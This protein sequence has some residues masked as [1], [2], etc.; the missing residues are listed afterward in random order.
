[1]LWLSFP[2]DIQVYDPKHE[3]WEVVRHVILRDVFDMGGV[4][5][6]VAGYQNDGSFDVP[7]LHR[8]GDDGDD[9]MDVTHEMELEF[10]DDEDI[11]DDEE[12][13]DDSTLFW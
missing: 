3:D 11:E 13:E 4:D 8:I 6:Q 5:D 7:N 12:N 2:N 10:L 1:M 9:G